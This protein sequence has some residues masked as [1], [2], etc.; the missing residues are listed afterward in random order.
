METSSKLTVESLIKNQ[1]VIIRENSKEI[2]TYSVIIY[3][4]DILA[5]EKEKVRIQ[6]K[7]KDFVTALITPDELEGIY[8]TKGVISIELPSYNT[9]NATF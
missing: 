4:S 5:L 3:T 9:T 1:P 7:S 6:S 8:Q 2:K